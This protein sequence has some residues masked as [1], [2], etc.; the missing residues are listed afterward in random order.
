MSEQICHFDLNDGKQQIAYLL[1]NLV[2]LRFDVTKSF[3]RNTFSD[4]LCCDYWLW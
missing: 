2:V 3:W 1:V 4:C